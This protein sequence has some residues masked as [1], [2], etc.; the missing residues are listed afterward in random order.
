MIKFVDIIQDLSYGDCGKGAV[1]Y[2]LSKK[3]EYDI[4]MRVNGG[5]NAGHTIY[6]NGKKFVTHQVPTGI[7]HGKTCIIGSG[8]VVTLSKLKKEI[9]ELE[10]EGIQ[11]RGKLFIANNAHIVMSSHVKEEEE[12]TKIGTTKQG[13]GPCYRDKYNRTGMR[14][15]YL[16]RFFLVEDGE[17]PKYGAI[18]GPKGETTSEFE[19]FKIDLYE[20]LFDANKNYGILVEGAQGFYLDID[21]GDYPYVSSSHSSVAGALLNCL[22]IDR[23]RKI[24]GVIKAYE[25]YVGARRFQTDDPAFDKL[26]DLGNEYGAT[27]GRRRQCNWLDLTRLVK[28]IN[29]NSVNRLIVSKFDILRELNFQE[30]DQ[31]W[32]VRA[33][34]EPNGNVWDVYTAANEDDFKMLLENFVVTNSD[35]LLLNNIQYKYGP[36]QDITI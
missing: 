4:C 12:E 18:T 20:F 11:V 17:E 9:E 28:A 25:T 6:H 34:R 7:F 27:T 33:T 10:A 1:A 16:N 8:C 24:Y 29:I 19:E 35:T 2:S 26:G 15:E 31:Q 5:S 30:S 32:K 23:V 14:F 13:I 22:P 3:S 21:H 36:E